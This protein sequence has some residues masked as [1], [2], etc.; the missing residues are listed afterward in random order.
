MLHVILPTPV[1]VSPRVRAARTLFIEPGSRWENGY[2]ESVNGKL[3]VELLNVEVFDT[4][5]EAKVLIERWRR[6]YNTIST[7]QFSGIPSTGSGADSVLGEFGKSEL[8]EWN[9]LRKNEMTIL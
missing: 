8:A 2:I 1:I 7:A 4:L 9:L 6:E 5:L 3:R